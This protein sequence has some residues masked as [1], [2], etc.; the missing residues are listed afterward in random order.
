MRDVPPLEDQP[1]PGDAPALTGEPCCVELTAPGGQVI[2]MLLIQRV[3]VEDVVLSVIPT[4]RAQ[5]GVTGPLGFKLRA[6]SE[7]EQKALQEMQ[8]QQGQ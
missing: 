2:G 4:F 7:T 1:R 8:A 5:T 6:L 3:P